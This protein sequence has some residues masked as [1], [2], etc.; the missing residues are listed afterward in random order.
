MDVS[1]LYTII[2]LDEGIGACEDLVKIIYSDLY[3][4]IYIIANKLISDTNIRY[5]H[6]YIFRLN[7]Q[8]EEHFK[9]QREGFDTSGRFGVKGYTFS[10]LPLL[11]LFFSALPASVIL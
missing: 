2:T 1:S 9:D 5:P 11:F 4:Y 6:I 3:I 7:Y 10:R 8:H